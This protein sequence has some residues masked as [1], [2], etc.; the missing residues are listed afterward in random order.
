MKKSK[1]VLLTGG[2]GFLGSN[3]LRKLIAADYNVV[4]L[5]RRSSNFSNIADMLDKVTLL[6]SEDADF[7]SL[8]AKN[9]IDCIVHCATNYGRKGQLPLA[10]LDSNLILPLKLLQIGAE[11]GLKCFINTDTVLGMN[12]S[13][14]SLSKAQFKE[15][16][17]I[18]SG[19]LVCVNMALEHFYGPGDDES[20]FV[21]WIIRGLLKQS[22]SIDLTSGDQKREFIYID[23][24]V[25]A[26]LRVIKSAVS[27]NNG[28]IPY[29]IGAEKSVKIREFVILVKSLM[30]NSRTRLNFGAI[31]YRKGEILEH[32]T[33]L[34]GIKKLG[35]KARIPLTTGLRKTITSERSLLRKE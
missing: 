20:K 23:D 10:I 16:L 9:R 17:K 33:D 35:W 5:V 13:H 29:E 26:F 14:Y 34:A 21:T 1:T 32:K 4:L 28:Y 8:F 2:T 27:L 30:K 18:Y 6:Y 22:K 11:N 31:P 24:V 7:G 15:W 19:R 25:D 3:L 12:I